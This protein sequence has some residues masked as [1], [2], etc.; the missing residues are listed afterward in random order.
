MAFHEES[1]LCSRRL[2]FRLSRD[3]LLAFRKLVAS[4][5]RLL[6]VY[7]GRTANGGGLCKFGVC[8][9]RPWRGNHPCRC[10]GKDY[11]FVCAWPK[12]TRETRGVL[13]YPVYGL[14]GDRPDVGSNIT[15][16][17]E[18][19]QITAIVRFYEHFDL[20][21]VGMGKSLSK[22]LVLEEIEAYTF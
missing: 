7:R 6:V 2:L 1:L 20:C 13:R 15:L 9:H 5:P 10:V 22:R 11:M 12:M 21:V 19:A 14:A 16:V 17:Q 3:G 8:A 4:A 18:E